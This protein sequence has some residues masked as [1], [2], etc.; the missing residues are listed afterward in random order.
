MTKLNSVEAQTFFKI[1]RAVVKDIPLLD[2]NS[3]S[4]EIT[5]EQWKEV[6]KMAREHNLLPLIL[7][8]ATED[9]IV[10]QLPEFNEYLRQTVI[11]VARQEKHTKAF[12][13]LY[14][15][16]A[17]AGVHPIVVKGLICRQIYGRFQ[18][19]R[20]SGDEDILV[21]KEDY[22]QLAIILRQQGF[23]TKNEEPT[24]EQL[25]KLREISFYD[26]ASGLSVDVHINL[27]GYASEWH[28]RANERFTHVFEQ[29]REVEIEGV[30]VRTLSHTDHLL[31]LILHALKHIS[32]SGVGI[33]QVMDILLYIREYGEECDWEYL[34]KIL[35]EQKADAFL[36]D[37]IYIGN[38]YLGFELHTFGE[39][40]CPEELLEDILDSG[41]FGNGTQMQQMAGQVTGVAILQENGSKK[42]RLR[43]LI[44]AIFPDKRWMM[45]R[46]PELAKKRWLLPV[47]WVRRWWTFLKEWKKSGINLPV[48][49]MKRGRRRM[50]LLKKY[51]RI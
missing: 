21:R 13:K 29:Y 51:G 24:E 15:A 49:G 33:R 42:S 34:H 43:I 44:D 25:E 11:S 48:E 19:H 37:F 39:P 50:E 31:F 26:V 47:Y 9:P 45:E 28:S 3:P 10:T 30:K 17:Q 18:Y 22:R 23:T 8:K 27:F 2:D 40:N 5:A 14:Q 7:E 12:L 38:R 35:Q 1:L 36:S 46:N 16:F 41:T 4:L 6:F 32:Y 20:V